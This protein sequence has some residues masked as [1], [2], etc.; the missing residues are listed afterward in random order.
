[1]HTFISKTGE[2]VQAER[3]M[4]APAL[5]AGYVWYNTHDKVWIEQPEVQPLEDGKLFGYDVAEFMAKQYRC[6]KHY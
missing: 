6:T 2:Q 5:H 1:M 3:F 4:Q